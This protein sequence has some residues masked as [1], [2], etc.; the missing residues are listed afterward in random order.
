ML[1]KREQAEGVVRSVSLHRKVRIAVATMTHAL[2][3]S[4]YF[5]TSVTSI[6]LK[7]SLNESIIK[8]NW[9]GGFVLIC[10]EHILWRFDVPP[11]QQHVKV[12]RRYD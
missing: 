8:K 6:T 1:N 12:S 4:F 2:T 3:H 10:G 11:N 7:V 5:Y 9:G